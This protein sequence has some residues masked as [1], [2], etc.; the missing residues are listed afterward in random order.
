MTRLT[1]FALVLCIAAVVA[2]TCVYV[3]HASKPDAAI[4]KSSSFYPK[5]YV[6]GGLN[7]NLQPTIRP[8]QYAIAL[9]AHDRV[10]NQTIEVKENFTIE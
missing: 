7:L 6:P 9:T 3:L 2:T 4:D 8:G 10:G 1:I 5:A